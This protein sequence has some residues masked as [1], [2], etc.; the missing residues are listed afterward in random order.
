MANR[1]PLHGAAAFGLAARPHSL[2]RSHAGA[3]DRFRRFRLRGH[4]SS[5]PWPRRAPASASP[6]ANPDAA[7]AAECWATSARSRSFRPI[8]AIQPPWRV[9]LDGAEGLRQRGGGCSMR[10]GRQRFDALHVEGAGPVA[11]AGRAAGDVSAARPDFGPRRRP[12]TPPAMPA[13][14]P[15][16]R[17]RYGGFPPG[18][19]PPPV[20]GVR[21][22]TTS[23][24]TG[25]PPW[26]GLAGPAADRRRRDPI[27]AGVRRRRAAA[28]AARALA[29]GHG[30]RADLRARRP[31][32]LHL[33]GAD[34]PDAGGDRQARVLVPLPFPVASLM[35]RGRASWWRAGLPA[36]DHPRSGGDAAGRQC[37][38]PR[39]AWASPTLGVP[40]QALE[41]IIPTYL[42]RYRRGGQYAEMTARARRCVRPERRSGLLGRRPERSGRAAGSGACRPPCSMAWAIQPAQ[43]ATEN[44][45][46]GASAGSFRASQPATRAKST[47]R[48]AGGRLHRLLQRAELR[49]RR[50]ALSR[51]RRAGIAVRIEQVAEARRGLHASRLA[52]A[53]AGPSGRPRRRSVPTRRRPAVARAGQRRQPG[54]RA[55]AS[56]APVEAATRAAKAEAFSSWSATSTRMRRIRSAPG[57]PGPSPRRAPGGCGSPRPEVSPATASAST[58]SRVAASTASARRAAAGRRV[59]AARAASARNRPACACRCSGGVGRSVRFSAAP[60]PPRSRRATASRVSVSASRMASRPR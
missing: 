5:A 13:P 47:L 60:W 29:I 52:M 54:Q 8:S 7:T 19:D 6:S 26:H 50:E 23:S 38:L 58:S 41:P 30:R 1:P 31:R 20:G 48:A 45:A 36:A 35:G 51:A 49:R 37:G 18:H 17:R 53:C 14:R 44:R 21:G 25:S 56:E 57:P 43:R 22:P 39:R 9:A 2:R 15:R 40:P 28:V 12:E 10:L 46:K 4:H 59:G 34:G 32:R 42:Y 16:A 11:G 27:P 55:A 33:Q 3:R 24:S